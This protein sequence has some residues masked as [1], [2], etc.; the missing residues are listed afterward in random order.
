VYAPLDTTTEIETPEHVR[1]R[2]AVAGP[3]RRAIAYLIDVI[4]RGA[5]IVGLMILAGFGGLLSGGALAAASQGLLL[6]V[7][8][9]VEWGTYVLFETLM[10]GRTPGKAALRLRVVTSSGHPLQFTHSVLRNLLRAADFLPLGYAL[11]LVV[12]AR[13]RRFRRL[14]DLVA[15]TMVVVEERHLVE[16]PIRIHPMPT[17]RELRGLPDR[18]PLGA[19]D[20]DAIE[21]LLRRSATLP[22][23]RE[24][25]LA[26]LV[27][28]LFANRLGVKF[29]DPHR[30]LAL[31]YHRARGSLAS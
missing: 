31:L 21:L 23:A 24:R 10:N 22:T 13:D 28:P 6:L 17:E 14:G 19:Q 8:F 7:L 16:G 12:M 18:L 2:H 9:V 15:G 3:V 25:E 11:G 1:F 27:A 5:V 29:E 4:I 30:F 20:L 26:E